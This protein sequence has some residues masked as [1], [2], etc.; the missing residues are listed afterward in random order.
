[1]VGWMDDWMHGWVNVCVSRLLV[2]AWAY[3]RL[4]QAQ[5]FYYQQISNTLIHTTMPPIIHPSTYP[6][7]YSSTHLFRR[8]FNHPLIR[9]STHTPTH[10][11]PFTHI[12]NQ[13]NALPSTQP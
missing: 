13:P 6:S 4:I 9:S 10:I 8:P 5:Q 2:V 12:S 3:G 1:M 7:L 11:Y